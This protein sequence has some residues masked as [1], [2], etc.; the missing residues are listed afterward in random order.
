MW[1][2]GKPCPAPAPAH[3]PPQ[4]LCSAPCLASTSPS[5]VLLL[6]LRGF[7]LRTEPKGT[8]SCGVGTTVG[9]TRALA[10]VSVSWLQNSSAGVP[11]GFGVRVSQPREAEGRGRMLLHGGAWLSRTK[12]SPRPNIKQLLLQP[13]RLLVHR[14]HYLPLSPLPPFSYQGRRHQ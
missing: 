9:R 12:N 11:G 10:Q 6:C 14:R 13:S 8:L 7:A 4:Q 1:S 5:P 2:S 3:P